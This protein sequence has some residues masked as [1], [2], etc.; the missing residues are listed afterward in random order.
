MPAPSARDR[1]LALA[2]DIRPQGTPV[3]NGLDMQLQGAAAARA[4][5][6]LDAVAKIHGDGNLPKIPL[7][8]AP[9]GRRAEAAF[10]WHD[11]GRRGRN[12]HAHA[13][14]NGA[15]TVAGA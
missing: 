3:A 10:G 9:P 5:R 7:A 13:D 4:Q 8:D 14:R 1:A 12:R 6:V 15:G 11:N 2:R